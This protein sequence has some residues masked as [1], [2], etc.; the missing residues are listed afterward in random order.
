MH[1]KNQSMLFVLFSTVLIMGAKL[2]FAQ[3]FSDVEIKI[4]PVAGQVY[5]L[6]GQGGNIGLFIGN[7]GVFLI[8]DQYAPLT[9]KIVAAIRTLSDEPIR[10]LINTH[11][12][13]DHTGGNE[14]FGKMGTLIFGHDNVR[15]QMQVAGYKEAPPLVTYG[16]DMSFHING[17]TVYV[18]KTP[19]AHTNGDSYI[20]FRG[21]NVVHTGDI[22]R[23]TSYP[24]VDTANGGSFLGTIKALDLLIEISDANTKIIPGHGV[25]SNVAEVRAWRDMLLVIRDRVKSSI[26][27]GKSLEETQGAGLTKE[28]DARWESG[29]RIGSAATLIEAAYNDLAR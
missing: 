10:F 11:M 20:L 23:T 14:N 8:D 13:P 16:E 4:H 7:D 15:H 19:D 25:I 29:R 5:Y 1:E 27:A 9:E 26:E 21:S 24:Y 22:Y 2:A 3:D 6:E 12:H 28:Y 18:F 17:E